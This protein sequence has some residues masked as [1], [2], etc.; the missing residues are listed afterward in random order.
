MNENL[1]QSE[2]V[3]RTEQVDFI[4]K[5][6]HWMTL[7]LLLTGAVAWWVS[8]TP[9]MIEM[10]FSNSLVFYGLLIGELLLVIYLTSAINKLS[11]VTASLLLMIYSGMNGLTLSVIFLA[12]TSASITTTFFIT[13]GTFAAMSIYG[14]TTKQDLTKIGNLAFMGLIG[15]IIASVV[16]LFLHNEV[17]YWIITYA[18]VLIF[19][20]L[21]AYDTQ[22]LKKMHE[23]GFENPEVAEK[24]AVMGALALYLDFINLFLF[25]LRIFGGRK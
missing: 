2:T 4:R 3:L 18:G 21:V 13:A 8:T 12:Y 22:K 11:S 14:Y 6:Y 7:S 24:G 1:P 20:G 16:N 9:T 23:E 5:V 25:L 17:M 19:V 15:I 10:I